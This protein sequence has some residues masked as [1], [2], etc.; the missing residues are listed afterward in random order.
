MSSIEKHVIA[1]ELYIKYNKSTAVTSHELGYPSRKCYRDGKRNILK[2][3]NRD[4]VGSV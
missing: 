3:K 2:K 4:L 1:V